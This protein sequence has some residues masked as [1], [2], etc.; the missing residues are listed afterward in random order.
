M[1]SKDSDEERVMHSI[2]DNPEKM[3]NDKEDE[4][5]EELFNHLFLDIRL[6][7]KDQ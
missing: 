4:V 7:W 5:T 6:G 2:S 3:I 1:S